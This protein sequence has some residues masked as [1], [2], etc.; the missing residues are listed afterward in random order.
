MERLKVI[1]K[2]TAHSQYCYSGDTTL[3]ATAAAVRSVAE[4]GGGSDGGGGGGGGGGGEEGAEDDAFV[5][6]VSD[7]NLRRYG[8]APSEPA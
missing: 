3:E 5:F 2:M 1:L 6:V 4:R 7:A 8:I